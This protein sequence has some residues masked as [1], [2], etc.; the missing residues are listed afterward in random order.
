MLAESVVAFFRLIQ[1]V[2]QCL[3]SIERISAKMAF[4]CK[5]FSH[6]L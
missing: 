4:E 3:P 1:Q 6:F 2:L 5:A